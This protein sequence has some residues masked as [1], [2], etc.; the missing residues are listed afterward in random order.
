MSTLY[1]KKDVVAFMP[2]RQM[3]SLF[4]ESGSVK[5]KKMGIHS[6]DILVHDVCW[7]SRR[8]QGYLFAKDTGIDIVHVNI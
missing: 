4:R 8:N 2:G 5:N 1:N 7:S 6:N 3:Q